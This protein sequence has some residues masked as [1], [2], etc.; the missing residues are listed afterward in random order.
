MVVNKDNF[1]SVLDS[2]N[3]QAQLGQL[4]ALDTE[5]TG[6]FPYQGDRLFSL[7]IGDKEETYYFNF[8]DYPDL[9]T[10]EEKNCVLDRSLLAKFE[11]VFSTP[12]SAWALHNAKF[13]MH[14]LAQ[15]NLFLKGHIHDTQIAGRLIE[16]NLDFDSGYSLDALAKRIGLK[17]DDAVEKYISEHKLKSK[18]TVAGK[19]F[20]ILHY[21]QVPWQIMFPYGQKDAEITRKL[22]VH[23]I[24]K[25]KEMADAPTPAKQTIGDLYQDEC[26]LLKVV[27]EMEREGIKVDRGYCLRATN[28]ESEF[29]IKKIEE[30]KQLTG[31]EFT[32][33]GKSL[34]QVFTKFK[35]HYPVTEKGNP[36]FTK[37]SLEDIKHPVAKL[38]LEIREA[39]KRGTTYFQNYIRFMDSE[40]KIHAQFNQAGT[41]TLRFSSSNPNLQNIPKRGDIE[42]KFPVKGAFILDS[43]DFCYVG[44]DYSQMEYRMM[45]DYAEEMEMIEKVKAGLDVHDA[46]VQMLAPYAEI[47]RDY[48]K[49]I[50]FM[51]LYGG[52]PPKLCLKIFNPIHTETILK[53]IFALHFYKGR[54]GEFIAHLKGLNDEQVEHDLEELRQAQSLRNA[55]FQAL[56]KVEK[57]IKLVRD[58]AEKR[59]YIHT[60]AG[61]RLRYSEGLHYKAPN[62][63]IQGGCAL[64]VKKAMNACHGLLQ[65]QKSKLLAQIHDELLFKIH[66]SELSIV[67]ELKK[68]M[69]EAYPHT[70]LAMDVSVG[71]SW[72]SWGSM[73]KGFPLEFN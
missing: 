59:G 68:A 16:N 58:V 25:L 14:M 30:F 69:I 2:L 73:Q 5:T 21:D 52:G 53:E 22:A 9:T 34:S 7:I 1:S 39:S 43:K 67:P 15:E 49:T 65:G 32:D 61:S 71:H 8:L 23:Q 13:D 28:H 56:P 20:T 3:K 36:S 6:L 51:T 24:R 27:F 63:L 10:K 66:K 26:D 44:M 57:F 33:S 35:L 55:Y 70:H 60:W 42:A 64:V 47:T 4:L 17:K 72:E 18:K 37:E 31:F 11:P 29:A 48:A 38:I 45:L 41:E 40:H 12:K 50:N 19:E 54:S 62:G 46:T